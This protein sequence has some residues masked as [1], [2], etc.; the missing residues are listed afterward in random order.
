MK[1]RSIV[2]GAL[3]L[4]FLAG[5]AAAQVN[6]GTSPLSGARGGT[7]NAFMQFSGPAGSLKTY[8]LPNASDTIATLNASQALTN[9]TYAG[10]SLA[11]GG[12]TLGSNVICAT[13]S[14]AVSGE[15]DSNHLFVGSGSSPATG[16]AIL[17]SKSITGTDFAGIQNSFTV[18][19]TSA[20]IAGMFVAPTLANGS[21]VSDLYAV[22]GE[23]PVL[24]GTAALGIYKV[25]R[26]DDL[27][28]L[29]VSGS[30]WAFY[31]EGAGAGGAVRFGNTTINADGAGAM[32]VGNGTAS[33]NTSVV[34]NG[35]GS[36]NGA[37][38]SFALQT[39][40]TNFAFVGNHSAIF[41]GAFATDTVMTSASGK[42]IEFAAGLTGAAFS[43]TVTTTVFPSGCLAV[44]SATDCGAGG[45]LANTDLYS[46]NTSFLIRTKAT[47]SNAAAAQTATLTN[48][49]TAGNPTKWISFDDNGTTRRIPAW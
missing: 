35:G 37:G 9:K 8:T 26:A 49:P 33:A 39:G 6:P 3:A 40:G 48:S 30:K 23:V 44:G 4:A 1:L 34:I 21:N 38:G 28:S 43:Q 29:T 41:G 11:I 5:P 7:N 36:G 45:I 10:S 27:T 2:A 19:G 25:F 32:I 42:K 31:A 22:R 46:N 24:Q 20:D 18:T 16:H 15:I 14:I 17:I 12:C 47:L 13:G